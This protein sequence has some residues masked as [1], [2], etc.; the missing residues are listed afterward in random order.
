MRIEEAGMEMAAMNRA[1]YDLDLTG[2][3]PPTAATLELPSSS[4]MLRGSS[5][6]VATLSYSRSSRYY[7]TA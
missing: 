2:F 1:L 7:F 5:G 4:R 6:R 3:L